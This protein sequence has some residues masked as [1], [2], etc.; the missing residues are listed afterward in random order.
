MSWAELEQ[1]S[2]PDGVGERGSQWVGVAVRHSHFPPL[3]PNLAA[4]VKS[5]ELTGARPGLSPATRCLLD[6]FSFDLF[7]NHKMGSSG[8]YISQAAGRPEEGDVCQEAH[9][10]HAGP[11]TQWAAGTLPST[12]SLPQLVK[13]HRS[14]SSPGFK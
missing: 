10:A 1:D 11:G 14:G 4:W 8:H 7:P 5:L 12:L 6:L 3:P 13:S 2:Q 9:W